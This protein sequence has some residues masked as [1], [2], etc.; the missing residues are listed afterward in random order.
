MG[1]EKGFFQSDAEDSEAR[2]EAYHGTV[3]RLNHLWEHALA[4]A[5]QARSFDR[6]CEHLAVSE[7]DL[8]IHGIPKPISWRFSMM[9]YGA[10][11]PDTKT[12]G[13]APSDSPAASNY[14][15]VDIG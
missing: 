11:D 5:T 3:E 14:F 6:L 9:P 2:E 12:T 8:P 13:F 10:G 1:V 15:L 4:D 7:G